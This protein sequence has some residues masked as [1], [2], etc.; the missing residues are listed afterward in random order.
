[1]AP[2]W[3]FSF[4]IDAERAQVVSYKRP[5]HNARLLEWHRRMTEMNGEPF[6]TRGEWILDELKQHYP[7]LSLAQIESIRA[8]DGADYYL[9]TQERGDLRDNLVHAND[10]YYLYQLWKPGTAYQPVAI[11]LQP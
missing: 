8:H 7:K 3:E 4:W 2:P 10:S 5:P 6:H 9:T 1:M 11:I